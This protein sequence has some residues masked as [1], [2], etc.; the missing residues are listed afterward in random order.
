MAQPPSAAH[1]SPVQIRADGNGRWT[2]F[3]IDGVTGAETVLHSLAGGSSDGSN[4]C[5]ALVMDKFGNLYGATCAGGADSCGEEGKECPPLC[6][7][8]ESDV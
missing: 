2:I 3:K 1:R 5:S 8:V 4:P 6:D 7:D